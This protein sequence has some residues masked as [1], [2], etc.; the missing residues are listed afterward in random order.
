[1]LYF[2]HRLHLDGPETTKVR[3]RSKN[4][5]Q[6]RRLTGRPPHRVAPNRAS[7]APAPVCHEG[8]P[9][10]SVCTDCPV[11]VVIRL[12]CGLRSGGSVPGW[13]MSSGALILHLFLI[14]NPMQLGGKQA[15]GARGHCTALRATGGEMEAFFGWSQDDPDNLDFCGETHLRTTMASANVPPCISV[16]CVLL[17]RYG[18]S[19]KQGRCTNLGKRCCAGFD[20]GCSS[21]G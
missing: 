15:S 1:M 14:Q 16:R 18:C 5:I 9:G 6:C 11:V 10:T 3:S 20:G 12:V 7:V 2:S 13:I 19:V 21:V 4:I 17:C 8:K